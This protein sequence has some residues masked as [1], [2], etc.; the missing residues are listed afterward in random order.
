MIMRRMCHAMFAI[1]K[2]SAAAG[3]PFTRG[4]VDMEAKTACPAPLAAGAR[5]ADDLRHTFRSR[6]W[7]LGPFDTTFLA[8]TNAEALSADHRPGP[9]AP[10]NRS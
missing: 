1:P 7:T 9:P 6:A 3:L 2:N 8:S 4:V 10:A 5:P